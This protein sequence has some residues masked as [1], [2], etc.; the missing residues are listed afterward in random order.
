MR[1]NTI[2][3]KDIYRKTNSPGDRR[4]GLFVGCALLGVS[5]PG[6]LFSSVEL[7]GF[8]V[9]LATTGGEGLRFEVAITGSRSMKD[10]PPKLVAVF[11]GRPSSISL[12]RESKL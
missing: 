10:F 3:T 11:T 4:V 6:F 9:G 12:R 2:K 8:L 5:P 1:C 7:R